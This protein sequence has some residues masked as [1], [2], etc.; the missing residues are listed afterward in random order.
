MVTHID[1]K[2][3][4]LPNKIAFVKDSGSFLYCSDWFI[5]EQVY[6]DNSNNQIIISYCDISD[7]SVSFDSN[8]QTYIGIRPKIDSIRI[9]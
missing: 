1:T 2:N 7:N 5:S 4:T 8:S 9:P 6:V 3:S